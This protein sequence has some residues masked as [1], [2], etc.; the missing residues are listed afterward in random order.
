MATGACGRSFE[1]PPAAAPQDEVEFLAPLFIDIKFFKPYPRPQNLTY[2]D[3]VL[4]G[5]GAF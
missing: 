1:T 3:R 5:E 2:P 4:S